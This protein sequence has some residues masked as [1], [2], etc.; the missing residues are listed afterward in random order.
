MS[1]LTL[2][3]A[4]LAISALGAALATSLPPFAAA[5]SATQSE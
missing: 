5:Q 3:T 2:L 1:R 4:A